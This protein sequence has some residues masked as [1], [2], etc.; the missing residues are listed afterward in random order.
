MRVAQRSMYNSFV[1]NMN[2]TL[3]NYMESNI[4]S[5]SQ[6]KV[7]RPSDDPVGMAR[8]LNYRSAIARN[9][10]YENNTHDAAA[11][12]RSTDSAMTQA[13]T[14][15]ASLQEKAEQLA[16]GTV[17]SEN[18][19]QTSHEIR[20]LFK[21][22]VNIAN[23]QYGDEHLFA[24]H[25][26]ASTPYE[27]GL[28]VT[29]SNTK[30]KKKDTVNLQLDFDKN[31]GKIVGTDEIKF[32][33]STDGTSWKEA[34]LKAG[35]TSVN[36]EGVTVSLKKDKVFGTDDI[37]ITSSDGVSPDKTSLLNAVDTKLD[38]GKV[39]V[40]SDATPVWKVS[41]SSDTTIMVRFP[42]GGTLGTAG[43]E[44]EYSKDGGETWVTMSPNKDYTTLDLDGVE[45]T[46]PDDPKIVVEAYDLDKPTARDNGSMLFIREAAYYNGDDNDPEPKVDSYGS[47]VITSTSAK[48]N[49][50]KDVRIRL[51]EDAF[52][53]TDG[54]V[55]Y[56]YSTDN[57]ITW[58]TATATTHAGDGKIRL[59]VPGGYLDV[60]PGAAGT[61]AA[62][63]QFVVRPQRAN[64]GLEIAE[65]EFLTVTNAGKDIFGGLY[66][67][68]DGR[69]PVAAMDGSAKNIFETVSEFL[70]WAETGVQAGSQE[71]LANLK[72]ASEG[73][74]TSLAAVGGKEQR[75]EL[76][77]NILEG[78]RFDMEDRMSTIED[79]DLTELV[80]KLAQQQMAYQSV[81]QSS[82]M[83]MQ[84]NLMSFL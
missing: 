75:A 7:N 22:L 74:L 79:V 41:G 45:V 26:T 51:D 8:V 17:T 20:Q 19:K 2:R 33:Y 65:G 28:A 62:G 10:Q 39:F 11:W 48:G 73:L 47:S 84:L 54:T 81:L 76:N 32:R 18:R 50:D 15:L 83:I 66:T 77:L 9:R 29:D 42:V 21:Q 13:Q 58:Q 61:L 14:I 82:S 43:V 30:T 59:N 69:G 5:S 53:N 12:L 27:I 72:T 23:T 56:S 24:G 49:F 31:V 71:A 44:Y 80:T 46:I 52:A 63:Q 78:S 64:Q 16:T 60:T 34:T 1:S 37:E 55:K 70:V 57:G 25:K 36:L 6:K 40:D 35:T 38:L 3:A 68:P 67:P 4:Q